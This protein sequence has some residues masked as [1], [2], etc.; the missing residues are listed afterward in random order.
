MLKNKI[1]NISI[2]N[3]LLIILI[4]MIKLFKKNNKEEFTSDSDVKE[5]NKLEKGKKIIVYNFNT[6]WCGYSREFEPIFKEF[7]IKN[8]S[9]SIII[10]DIKCDNE[11][12]TEL[13]KKY[14]L[15]GFPTV[16]FIE[17]DKI[18]EYQG[19]RTLEDLTNS[20]NIFSNKL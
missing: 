10:K 19:N 14:K 6:L 13:C 5:P 1:L 8:Q 3:W 9:D 11:N 7:K 20:L 16:L 17:G 12:N 15:P 18:E 2:Y 4:I